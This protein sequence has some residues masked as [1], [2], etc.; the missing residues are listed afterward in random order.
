MLG[1]SVAEAKRRLEEEDRIK[2]GLAL[3]S[4]KRAAIRRSKRGYRYNHAIDG[5]PLHGMSK[6]RYIKLH[7]ASLMERGCKGGE[8]LSEDSDF[9]DWML[10]RPD[11]EHCRIVLQKTM[12]KIGWTPPLTNARLKNAAEHGRKERAGKLVFDTVKGAWA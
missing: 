12:N 1:T 7:R 3:Q 6:R 2:D 5:A 11:M 4:E 10:K 9:T 8:L